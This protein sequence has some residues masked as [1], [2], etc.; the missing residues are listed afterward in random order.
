MT[1]LT[2]ATT[3]G[4]VRVDY[5]A[6][7]EETDRVIGM[8]YLEGEWVGSFGTFSDTDM[9]RAV[10]KDLVEWEFGEE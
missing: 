5:E 6:V 3:K 1:T 7:P 10:V 4:E 9:I 2:V 8:V